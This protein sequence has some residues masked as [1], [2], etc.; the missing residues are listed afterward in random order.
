MRSPA[1]VLKFLR[2]RTRKLFEHVSNLFVCVLYKKLNFQIQITFKVSS[3]YL[4]IPDA[5]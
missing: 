1:G 4:Y 3:G 2:R 5:V